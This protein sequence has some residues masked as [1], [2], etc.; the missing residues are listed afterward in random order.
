MPKEVDNCVESILADNPE[1]DESTAWAICYAQRLDHSAEELLSVK[2]RF[3]LEHE[4]F[5][6]TL[7]LLA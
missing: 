1:M 3:N 4:E 6:E 5:V 7:K 2:S